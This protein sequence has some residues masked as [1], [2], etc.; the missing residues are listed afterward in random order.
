MG[1]QQLLLIV[2]GVI[3]VG[4]AIVVGINMFN[5]SAEQ[6]TKDDLTNQGM[7]IA[8]LAQQYYK[9]PAAMGGGGNTFTGFTIP[10]DL[11]TTPNAGWTGAPTATNIVLTGNPTDYTWNVTVTVTPT[12]ITTAFATP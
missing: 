10:A 5:A 12:G 9:K 3:I 2:L 8:S 7:H 4:I 1:Q 6:A 11:A